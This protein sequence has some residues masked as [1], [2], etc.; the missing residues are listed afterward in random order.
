M[1]KRMVALLF[2]C[3]FLLNAQNSGLFAQLTINTNPGTTVC[4]GT[5][6]TLT[7]SGIAG[8]TY[9]WS[10]SGATTASIT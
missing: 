10:P 4:A 7:A 6:V 3:M 5:A 2:L 9:S 8:A 1:E